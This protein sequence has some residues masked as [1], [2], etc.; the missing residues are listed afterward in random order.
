MKRLYGV[1]AV[2]LL[3]VVWSRDTE[4]F[5]RPE[6]WVVLKGKIFKSLNNAPIDKVRV[7]TFK[8]GKLIPIPFQ[9]DKVDIDGKFVLNS[10]YEEEMVEAR[11]EA[12]EDAL[13][14]E[15]FCKE[16]LAELKRKAEWVEDMKI[17]DE[18]DELV[19][20]AW[21]LG[22]KAS[23]K[24]LPKATKIEEI[25][26][27]NPV[28]SSTGYAYV[29]QF[30]SNPPPLSPVMYVQ[31][32]RKNDKVETISYMIDFDDNRPTIILKTQEKRTDGTLGPN[33]FDK[34]KM[35]IN[36]DVKYFFTINMDEDNTDGEILAYHAGPVRI[37]KSM[38]LWVK[39]FFF[40]VTPDIRLDYVFYS[41]GMIGPSEISIPFD[42]KKYVNEGSYL[43]IGFDYNDDMTGAK[44]YTEKNPNP[45]TL[46]GKMSEAEKALNIEDQNWFVSY[47]GEGKYGY[48]VQILWDKKLISKGFKNNIKY[49]DDKNIELEPEN[50]PGQHLVGFHAKIR[51]FHPADTYSF[52]LMTFM[53]LKWNKGLEKRYLNFTANPLKARIKK[54]K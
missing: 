43:M 24:M 39:L 7:F 45:V 28:D 12:Y 26:M 10:K 5:S 33:N 46:D 42:T 34:F 14:E 40:P 38:T 41:N 22:S 44:V 36:I 19:F 31:Y 4:A 11:K 18:Q 16:K 1:I 6:G 2:V 51:D 37:I 48:L 50:V 53:D 54:I 25:K 20:M 27:T 32:D 8:K 9:I 21:D 29:A 49:L 35:R 15:N 23:G 3:L 13:D 52:Y 47:R 17:F 30:G